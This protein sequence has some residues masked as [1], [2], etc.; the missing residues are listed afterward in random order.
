MESETTTWGQ[1][2]DFLASSRPGVRHGGTST[3]GDN[4]KVH[5][6]PADDGEKHF[7]G[8]ITIDREAVKVNS[9]Q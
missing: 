2:K 1:Y 6:R 3:G 8:E 4:S 9:I 5:K 7:G